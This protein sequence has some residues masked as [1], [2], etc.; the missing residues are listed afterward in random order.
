MKTLIHVATTI[1]RLGF[2]CLFIS[3]CAKIGLQQHRKQLILMLRH[4]KSHIVLRHTG[5]L[6]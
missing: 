4:F 5:G 3:Y 1:Q 2:Y 6:L